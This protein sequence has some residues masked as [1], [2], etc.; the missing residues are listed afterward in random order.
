MN[1]WKLLISGG[2]IG[3]I[4]SSVL[5]MIVLYRLSQLLQ[6]RR[7]RSLR[8]QHHGPVPRFGGI[9]LFWGFAGTLL[10]VWMLPFEQRGL[11]FQ[12][13]SENRFA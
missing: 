11:G 6:S 1:E 12:L 2:M 7:V 4:V 8:D 13:L 3:L 5:V 9:A 10:L